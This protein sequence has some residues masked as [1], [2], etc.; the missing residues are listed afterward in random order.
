LGYLGVPIFFVVSGYCIALAANHS[1]NVSDFFVRR[2]FR[3]FPLYWFSLLVVLACVAFT[4]MNQGQNSLANI[5]KS[6]QNISATLLLLT[7]P[8]SSVKTINWVYW[9]LTVEL[10][11]YVVIASS[12]CFSKKI[13]G[14]F[15]LF[16]SVLSCFP[17]LFQIPGLFFLQQWPS[18][19]IGL[20]LFG[21]QMDRSKWLP[22]FLLLVNSANLLMGEQ[23]SYYPIVSFIAFAI[24]AISIFLKDIPANGISK[25]GDFSYA[26]YLLHVPI[27]IYLFGKLK[28]VTVQS[29][30]IY[31]VIYDLTMLAGLI[32]VSTVVYNYLELPGIK[33]GKKLAKRL[34]IKKTF[35]S[36]QA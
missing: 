33:F 18:F 3:I 13:R 8:F 28:T 30:L 14:Y 25:L 16:V 12:L 7:S 6:Y 10:F 19:G 32:V 35:A 2:I 34:Q 27:G 24:I 31:N 26:V 5:P 11:F 15:I 17:Q 4:I 9:S 1:K 22:S 23:P 20:A 36:V 21:L 29:N